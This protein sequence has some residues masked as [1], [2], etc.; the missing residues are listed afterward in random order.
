MELRINSKS[1]QI[2][3]LIQCQAGILFAINLT[4]TTFW[5]SLAVSGPTDDGGGTVPTGVLGSRGFINAG[6]CCNRGG[7]KR[8]DDNLT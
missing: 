4:L 6:R 2:K 1:K 8:Y 5:L 7:C 3:I